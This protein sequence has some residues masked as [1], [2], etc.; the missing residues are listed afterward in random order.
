MNQSLTLQFERVSL[1]SQTAGINRLT[2]EVSKILQSYI[3]NVKSFVQDM[4][5]PMAGASTLSFASNNAI[6]RMVAKTNYVSLSTIHVYV[7]PGMNKPWN[8]FL[9]ALEQSQSIAD[10]LVNETLKPAITYFSQLVGNPETLS[11]ISN[12]LDAGQIVF[13]QKAIED[14]KAATAACYSKNGTEGRRLFGDVFRR[15]AEWHEANTRLEE[16]TR[17]MS[18]VSP[19]DVMVHV[20]N[21][22][23]VMDRLIIRMRQKPDVYAVSGVTSDAMS[24]IA[25][26]L[27]KEVEFYA[28]HC[29]LLQTATA[30]MTDTIRHLAEATAD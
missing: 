17:R 5:K 25:M 14:C 15:N 22:S 6:N 13:H 26:E 21:L 18:K 16:L 11:S 7:P 1:E 19:G 30:A 2:A 24:V 29:F 10:V 28:A 12:R 20:D 3:G 9:D 27:A 8:V 23:E 4:V